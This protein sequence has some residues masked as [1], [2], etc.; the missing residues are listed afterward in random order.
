VVSIAGACGLGKDEVGAGERL[1]FAGLA[2]CRGGGG[3]GMV[4]PVAREADR[5]GFA[6][7]RAPLARKLTE[8]G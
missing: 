3:G 5:A 4:A 1:R 6:A 8:I 7:A 2:G